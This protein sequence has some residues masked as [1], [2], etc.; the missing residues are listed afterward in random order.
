MTGKEKGKLREMIEVYRIRT[1]K[2]GGIMLCPI[3]TNFGR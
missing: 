3:K 2:Q 1:F